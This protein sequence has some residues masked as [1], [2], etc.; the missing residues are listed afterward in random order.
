MMFM[1][2]CNLGET[3]DQK[4]GNKKKGNKERKKKE[5][6]ERRKKRR[7]IESQKKIEMYC[8]YFRDFK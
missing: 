1:Q 4:K 7:A 5:K 8:Y 3:K 2:Y 6:R